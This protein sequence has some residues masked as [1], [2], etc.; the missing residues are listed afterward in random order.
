MVKNK[1]NFTLDD[2][3]EYVKNDFI[4]V[5]N[6]DADIPIDELKEKFRKADLISRHEIV[7]N[8]Y[9]SLIMTL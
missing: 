2:T 5:D 1:S 6:A 7:N 3:I 8:L 4:S 9:K